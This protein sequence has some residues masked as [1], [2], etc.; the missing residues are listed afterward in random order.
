M[1]FIPVIKLK[2][3]EIDKLDC[4]LSL[5]DPQFTI[6]FIEIISGHS[7]KNETLYIKSRGKD[8]PVE[9]DRLLFLC[10]YNQYSAIKKVNPNAPSG[11]F[12]KTI[13]TPNDYLQKS[14]ELFN[15]KNAIPTYM[16][17]GIYNDEQSL[18]A[19][20]S[21]AHSH[22]KP[23]CIRLRSTTLWAL[24]CLSVLSKEDWILFDMKTER[25]DLLIQT[26]YDEIK[27]VL[28]KE[29]TP[30]MGV[31]FENYNL[32]SSYKGEDFYNDSSKTRSMPFRQNVN[33]SSRKASVCLDGLDGWG[34][35]CGEKNNL[36]EIGGPSNYH[37]AFL[38]R[39]DDDCFWTFVDDGSIK[40]FAKTKTYVDG[41]LKSH[42][43]EYPITNSFFKSFQVGNFS[44]YWILCLIAYLEQMKA[45]QYQ[46]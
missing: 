9:N 5:C 18:I 32:D 43:S 13:Q 14:L 21:H 29:N 4:I 34:D 16:I 35:Y 38:Y 3:T 30:H 33:T 17:D 22:N 24:R 15:V 11:L 2:Q 40:I 27:S 31:L 44:T 26:K 25:E 46:R 39:Y 28:N 19:F 1:A 37:V 8:R 42:S 23:C 6:P 10:V 45:H 20:I 7:V 12:Y 41:F 36:T